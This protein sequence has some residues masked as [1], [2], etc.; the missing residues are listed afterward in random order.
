MSR[1]LWENIAKAKQAKKQEVQ[2]TSLTLDDEIEFIIDEEIK[3][4]TKWG[5]STVAPAFFLIPASKSGNYHPQFA[6]TKH[7]LVKHIK[8][9]V[10][11][12]MELFKDPV[13]TNF[14]QKEKDIIISALILHDIGKT[15]LRNSGGMFNSYVAHGNIA[16]KH[17]E[18]SMR[19]SG[20]SRLLTFL[21]SN[22]WNLI[23]QAI[24]YHM[25]EFTTYKEGKVNY[26]YISRFVHMCDYLASRKVIDYMESL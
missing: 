22:D 26:N 15:T 4:F 20:D 19:D 13:I 10:R 25:G 11:I 5:L 2:S 8:Y 24:K 23:G 1:E 16:K 14:T 7:G 6:N 9:A 21:N 12:A 3:Y 18:Q 17:L